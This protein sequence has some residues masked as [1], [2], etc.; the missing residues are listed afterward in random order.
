MASHYSWQNENFPL[1]KLTPI[2]ENIRI[3]REHTRSTFAIDGIEASNAFTTSLI[4][5]FREITLNGRS[6]RSAL[7][8]LSA[9]KDVTFNSASSNPILIREAVTTKAS[10]AFQYEV[11]YGRT[12]LL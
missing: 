2:I 3:K 11:R 12:T 9:C 10:M 8:A 7:K 4:P 1:K 6:P 5:S